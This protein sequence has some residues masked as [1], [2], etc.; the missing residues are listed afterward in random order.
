M[1][2]LDES[3]GE[4]EKRTMTGRLKSMIEVS[5][6]TLCRLFGRAPLSFGPYLPTFLSLARSIVVDHGRRIAA[7]GDLAR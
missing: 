3:D 1:F 5:L 6:E 2:A 4:E 7:S